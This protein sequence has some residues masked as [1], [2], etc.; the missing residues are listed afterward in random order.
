MT[1]RA[2]AAVLLLALPASAQDGGTFTLYDDYHCPEGPAMVQVD[3]GWL[4]TDLRKARIDCALLGAQGE[5]DSWR[6]GKL[7]DAP[8]PSTFQLLPSHG[9]LAALGSLATWYL[10]TILDR[11][12]KNCRGVANPFEKC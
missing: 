4:A 6:P 12:Q 8:Q 7:T 11:A 9:V 5:L 3:G 10:K 1:Q 2:I